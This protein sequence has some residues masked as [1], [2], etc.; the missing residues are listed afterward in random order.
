MILGA[1]HYDDRTRYS[2]Q[3]N[4][5]TEQILRKR[6]EANWLESC[7][8]TAAV[9]CLSALGHDV[10]ISTPG[11]W[12]PQPEEVL[13]DWFFDYRNDHFTGPY[14]MP[15]RVMSLYAPAV[16]SVFGV[17][18]RVADL[19]LDLLA[20]YLKEGGAVQLLLHEPGHYIAAVAWDEGTE[21]VLYWDSWPQRFPDGN[22][23]NRRLCADEFKANAHPTGVVYP[24]R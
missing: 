12:E 6:R 8:P 18:V 7:G 9:N 13:L 24:R 5:P 23:F 17:T 11:V 19:N 22:G 16:Y 4:N 3:T 21:E 2:I 15:N 10:R 20:A 1:A 14:D